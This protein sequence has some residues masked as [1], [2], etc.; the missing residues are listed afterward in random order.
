LDG[1][2]IYKGDHNGVILLRR[3][4]IMRLPMTLTNGGAT[5]EAACRS[6]P[7]TNKLLLLDRSV[8]KEVEF[9]DAA[10]NEINL[11]SK[12]L[13]KVYEDAYKYCDGKVK[14]TVN[15]V[16]QLV[17]DATKYC[18]D[19]GKTK[20]STLEQ[21]STYL[22]E[23]KMTGSPSLPAEIAACEVNPYTMSAGL[24]KKERTVEAVPQ[25]GFEVYTGPGCIV[26]VPT[27]VP[28]T[29]IGG[30]DV[31]LSNSWAY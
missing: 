19:Q 27:E 8:N 22:N 30:P 16:T 31:Q 9:K 18:R 7:F 2:T 25:L 11:S 20:L 6:G 12:D 14:G 21:I 13:K 24:E 23:R 1:G 3:T 5:T 28:S 4:E 15:Q 17:N 10:G 26:Y 29:T